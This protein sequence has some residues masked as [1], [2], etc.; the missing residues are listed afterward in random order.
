MMV[1][2]IT[3]TT[4][5]R[6]KNYEAVLLKERLETDRL[7]WRVMTCEVMQSAERARTRAHE[8]SAVVAYACYLSRIQ[9]G[10][11][12]P[13]SIYGEPLLSQAL[14]DLMHELSIERKLV[15]DGMAAKQMAA[16]SSNV[17]VF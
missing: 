9:S 3:E 4:L 8:V 1:I 16:V 7:Q 12:E 17:P 6:L 5:K 11:D 2:E 14:A 10:R 15:A 13:R